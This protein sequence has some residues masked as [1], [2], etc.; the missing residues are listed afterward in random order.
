MVSGI[1]ALQH[2]EGS[3]GDR[4]FTATASR[5]KHKVE[6]QDPLFI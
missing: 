6:S 5:S 3:G 1:V 4:M 2:L